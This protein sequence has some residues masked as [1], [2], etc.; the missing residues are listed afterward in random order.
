[1]RWAGPLLWSD[2]Q[3][4]CLPQSIRHPYSHSTI[5]TL[6][7]VSVS[8][9]VPTLT[10]VTC[11]LAPHLY[12]RPSLAPSLPWRRLWAE[13]RAFLFGALLTQVPPPA[14]RALRNARER[15]LSG[16]ACPALQCT[17]Q[18]SSRGRHPAPRWCQG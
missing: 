2:H 3:L 1:M 16:A 6:V 17:P 13:L 10:I 7:N 8:Y 12:A 4:T 9:G 14:P 18:F 11:V 15:L 5:S